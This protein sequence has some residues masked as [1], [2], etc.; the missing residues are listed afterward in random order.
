[1][2]MKKNL[3]PMALALLATLTACTHN[4]LQ[5]QPP[6]LPPQ[7]PV[8]TPKPPVDS[9]TT[10]SVYAFRTIKLIWNGTDT[11]YHEL[12]YDVNG[13]LTHMTTQMLFNLG[14]GEVKRKEME[15]VYAGK[16][17]TR[18][19]A[20]NGSV[21][22]YFDYTYEG[23][24]VARTQEFTPAGQLIATR[25]YQYDLAKRLEAVEET[26]GQGAGQQTSRERFTYDANGNLTQQITTTFQSGKGG[27]SFSQIVRYADYDTQRTIGNRDL[28]FPLLPGVRLQVN[29]PRTIDYYTQEGN[30]SPVFSH[31]VRFAYTYT[32]K[33][34]PASHTER[35]RII[36]Y[37]Y[38]E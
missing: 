8:V 33:G 5:P 1:M 36:T 2:K 37:S 4:A 35:G 20:F 15:L 9:T 28:I 32:A 38:V 24:Q 13:Q 6:V 25:S 18:L 10:D 29:N 12:V 34:Y 16:Y 30:S 27:A 14:T 3:T 23:D 19:N 21:R 31:Q 22:T 26:R 11:D 17:I 7:P